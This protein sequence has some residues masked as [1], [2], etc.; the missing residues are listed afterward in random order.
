VCVVGE[1]AEF[2]GVGEEDRG[3]EGNVVSIGEV[4]RP[5]LCVALGGGSKAQMRESDGWR[6]R[7]SR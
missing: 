6:R 5:P 2:A 1:G 3:E 4:A 7:S